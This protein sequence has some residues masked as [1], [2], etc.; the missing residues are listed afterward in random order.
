MDNKQGL[1]LSDGITIPAK[2]M[3]EF[4][5]FVQKL[6]DGKTLYTHDFTN[7]VVLSKDYLSQMQFEADQQ[8][9]NL[10]PQ[11]ESGK[12]NIDYFKTYQEAEGEK[13]ENKYVDFSIAANAPLFI[14]LGEEFQE[15]EF[16][17]AP[18]LD[19]GQ[20]NK[21]QFAINAAKIAEDQKRAYDRKPLLK[22]VTESELAQSIGSGSAKLM[23]R[24]ESSVSVARERGL[25][26][27]FNALLR[28]PSQA[29]NEV[30]ET[31]SVNANAQNTNDANLIEDSANV[32]VS[33]NNEE[34]SPR[35][36]APATKQQASEDRGLMASLSRTWSSI[37][38]LLKRNSATN[39]DQQVTDAKH[40]KK[41][42]SSLVQVQDGNHN[43]EEE[44]LD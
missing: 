33:D 31:S 35:P 41:D 34:Q 42:V 28:G 37:G 44:E 17:L 27:G 16:G 5:Q 40:E 24:L 22:K 39:N 1:R 19:E 8:V 29:S 12:F 43:D 36:V 13:E 11:V 26:A 18:S 10:R 3:L 7:A 21:I 30:V 14:W 20:R 6:N 25:L 32:T 9:Y 4:L 2:R 23:Q 15:D 38:V